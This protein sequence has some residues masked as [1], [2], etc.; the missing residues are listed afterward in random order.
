RY[1]RIREGNG[2]FS[3]YIDY[4]KL[5]VE[6]G[7]VASRNTFSLT[8]LLWL[9]LSRLIL[10]DPQK[11]FAK[12]WSLRQP[13]RTM[14]FLPL[15]ILFAPLGSLKNLLVFPFVWMERRVERFANDYNPSSPFWRPLNDFWH[16]KYLK[17]KRRAV[18]FVDRFD[19]A[20]NLKLRRANTL[21]QCARQAGILDTDGEHIWFTNEFWRDYFTARNLVDHNELDYFLHKH[22]QSTWKRLY[23]GEEVALMASGL[24]KAPVESVERVFAYDTITASRCLVTLDDI[25][26]DVRTGL[27]KRFLDDLV[28]GLKQV[29]HGGN[30]GFC[31]Q[32]IRA[33]R[34]LTDNPYYANVSLTKLP[35]IEVDE[36]RISAA[37]VIATYG[38][39]VYEML[40]SKL[41]N[42]DPGEK[43]YYLIALGELKDPRAITELKNLFNT[44]SEYLNKVWAVIILGTYFEDPDGMVDLEKYLRFEVAG[45]KDQD[46]GRA[47]WYYVDFCGEK[48][49]GFALGVMERA[50]P[51][52]KDW[53]EPD[54]FRGM[55]DPMLSKLGREYEDNPEVESLLLEMLIRPQPPRLTHFLIEALGKVKSRKAIPELTKLLSH[56]DD[57]LREAAVD[58]LKRI[59]SVALSSELTGLIY[60]RN[61]RLAGSAIWALS[62]L[63]SLD[64]IPA[65]I[66]KLDSP[67]IEKYEHEED[68]ERGYPIALSAMGALVKI[69]VGIYEDKNSTE[70]QNE[71]MSL[72]FDIAAAWCKAHLN[73]MRLVRPDYKT[74]SNH[75][76]NYLDHGIPIEKAHKYYSDWMTEHPEDHI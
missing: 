12:L 5:I 20:R 46:P 61:L 3:A 74:V 32:S 52:P 75:A 41:Q 71:V 1:P 57:H 55:T 22:R 17:F 49:I 67:E 40:V 39:P 4:E 53:R 37:R 35:E 69:G 8:S 70:K 11:F 30:S 66:E 7:N 19:R 42:A 72:C 2:R 18:R 31:V 73:D 58:A 51:L 33:L 36:A 13:W 21:L 62:A 63:G 16:K 27:V 28:Q 9:P 15:Y 6:L 50:A 64:A 43:K 47:A 24:S 60:S 45:D 34:S 59:D 25:P 26:E 65:L 76:L 68:D 14:V 23:R 10:K 44:T 56:A 54:P 38:K 29:P 48:A